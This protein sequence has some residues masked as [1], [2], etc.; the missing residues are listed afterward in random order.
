MNWYATC[1]YNDAQK[2]SF[3]ATGRKRLKASR[4]SPRLRARQHSTSETTAAASR[5]SGEVTLHAESLYVQICQPATGADSGILI[6]TCEGRKD[7]TGGRNNFAAALAA[8]RHSELW[9]PAAAP[10]SSME[11]GHEASYK[12]TSREASRQWPRAGESERNQGRKGF[13]AGRQVLLSG[14]R[15]DLAYYRSRRRSRRYQR[16]I[17]FG[18]ADL[19]QG[20]PELGSVRLSELQA[21]RGRFSLGIERDK[22]FKARAPLSRYAEFAREAGCI[23]EQVTP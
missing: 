22:F 6:R 13:L 2:Q 12:R 23:T 18:L 21:F 11:A 16:S 3:H 9:P 7:Y 1:A 14:R 4:R 17:L 8:R 5:V 19:G 15:G 10:C 20:F